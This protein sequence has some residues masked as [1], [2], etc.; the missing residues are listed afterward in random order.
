MSIRASVAGLNEIAF[1]GEDL[2][3]RPGDFAEMSISTAWDAAV[4]GRCAFRQR[5][6]GLGQQVKSHG[7]KDCHQTDQQPVASGM[8]HGSFRTP[9]A[10]LDLSGQNVHQSCITC[11]LRCSRSKSE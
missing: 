5:R 7:G 6:C 3:I 11:C 2:L 8:G 4:A 9:V 1:V 10:G